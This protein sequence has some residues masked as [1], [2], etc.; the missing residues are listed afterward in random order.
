LESYGQPHGKG[1]Q[2]S[3]TGYISEPSN[4]GYDADIWNNTVEEAK[5]KIKLKITFLT[6]FLNTLHN[7]FNIS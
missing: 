7:L 4:T 5:A 1:A 6:G 3:I 2:V